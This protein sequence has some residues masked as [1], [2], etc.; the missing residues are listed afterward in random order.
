MFWRIISHMSVSQNA[1]MMT[2]QFSFRKKVRYYYLTIVF[3]AYGTQNS[4]S[5]LTTGQTFFDFN[6]CVGVEKKV[7]DSKIGIKVVVDLANSYRNIF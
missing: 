1:K 7:K 6:F 3:P 2:T 5:R 4:Y